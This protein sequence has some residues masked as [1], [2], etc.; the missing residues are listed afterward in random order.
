MHIHKRY[1]M[2]EISMGILLVLAGFLALFAFFDLIGEVKNVGNSGYQLQHAVFFV[3]LRLPGRLYEVMPFAVLIGALYTLS[4]LARHSEK[5][6][7]T[8][9]PQTST[10]PRAD[11]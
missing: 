1:L 2:R 5:A 7:E 9:P 8:R 10:C 6:R 11:A 4:A 3:L